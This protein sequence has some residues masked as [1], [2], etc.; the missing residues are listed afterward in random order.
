MS[1]TVIDLENYKKH[2]TGFLKVASQVQMDHKTMNTVVNLAASLIEE[3]SDI[4]EQLIE[5]QKL[6]LS[7]HKEM[8]G[9]FLYVSGQA[10]CLFE[11]LKLKN[12]CNAEDIENLWQKILKENILE[13][14]VG[15]QISPDQEE[16]LE[17]I[18]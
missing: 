12:V 13:E 10:F 3:Q 2:K 4:I 16:I 14:P 15:V 9:Q 11:L 5:N 6:L 7:K 18:S 1:D 17:P 8:Q